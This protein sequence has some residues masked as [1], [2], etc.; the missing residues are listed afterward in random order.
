MRVV[1]V[2]YMAS[3]KTTV[4]RALAKALGV[5]FVDLDA[6]IV[7]QQGKSIA[8]IF[9]EEGEAFFRQLEGR[10]L[11]E[12]LHQHEALVLATGGGTPCYGTAMDTILENAEH[13]VYLTFSVPALVE[14]IEGEKAQRPLVKDLAREDLAAFV[15]QHLS[16]RD[17]FYARAPHRVVGDQKTVEALVSEI[18][19]LLA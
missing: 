2:G 3:G 14:R 5:M 9:E 13:T 6:Y 8:K 16:K 17:A 19:T 15:A 4:G 7:Q 1:L 18:K 11:Q 10:L 12:V